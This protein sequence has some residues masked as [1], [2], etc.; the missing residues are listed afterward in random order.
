MVLV[1]WNG[2]DFVMTNGHAAKTCCRK[3]RQSGGMANDS[4]LVVK[5]VRWVARRLWY[6]VG[7]AL[8]GPANCEH[9]CLDNR[10]GLGV[11]PPASGWG[12]KTSA[13]VLG[14]SRGG[15]TTTIHALVEG[16]G[17]LGHTV[18]SPAAKP[19]RSRGPSEGQSSP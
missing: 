13:Q 11:C 5:V 18:H 14:R 19:M 2:F 4:Q 16:L 15:L 17:T 8:A 6:P 9:V 7:E 1:Q 12:Q 10:P 3:S